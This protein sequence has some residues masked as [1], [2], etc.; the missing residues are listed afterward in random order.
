MENT[1]L[2]YLSQLHYIHAPG[3]NQSTSFTKDCSSQ[4]KKTIFIVKKKF[5]GAR[6]TKKNQMLQ[7]LKLLIR[8]NKNVELIAYNYEIW[9]IAEYHF[10]EQCIS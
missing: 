6:L 4:F 9:K 3:C 2:H 10:S 5:S 7:M 1:I 8:Q